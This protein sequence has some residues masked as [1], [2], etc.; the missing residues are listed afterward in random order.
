MQEKSRKDIANRNR[1]RRRDLLLLADGEACCNCNSEKNLDVVFVGKNT[2][3]SHTFIL[4]RRC[5]VRG[6]KDIL[7]L[8]KIEQARRQRLEEM[9]ISYE[10]VEEEFDREGKIQGRGRFFGTDSSG[11]R[12]DSSRG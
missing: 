3:F 11:S 5:H 12:T 4:C 2:V 7:R 1:Y 9:G 8:D 6:V 10:A